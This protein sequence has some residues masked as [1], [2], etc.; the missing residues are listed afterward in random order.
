MF[1]SKKILT[2]IGNPNLETDEK[3]LL[4]IT[5]SGAGLQFM[6]PILNHPTQINCPIR[7]QYLAHYITFAL[8]FLMHH[9]FAHIV[10]GHVGY[11]HSK[12]NIPIF[13]EIE[14]NSDILGNPGSDFYQTIEMDADSLATNREFLV[15]H[16]HIEHE[17]STLFP[18]YENWN[19]FIFHWVFAIYSLFRLFGF[20]PYEISN[21]KKLKHPP[22]SLRIAMIISTLATI[23]EHKSYNIKSEID[24]STPL[25][26]SQ[27]AEKAFQE[28]SYFPQGYDL[29]L[30]SW[31]NKEFNDY[32]FEITYNWNNVRPLLEPFAYGDLPPLRFDSPL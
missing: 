9:E 7:K 24:F 21:A 11:L 19:T 27:E 23:L 6:M 14:S 18:I 30:I 25:K 4:N 31:R 15:A 32:L 12:Y 17:K 20:E 13:P 3:K 5:K 16:H 28:I 26:A 2:S 8:N 29:F 10:R 1:S 22:P